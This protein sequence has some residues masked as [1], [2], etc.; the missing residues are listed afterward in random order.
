MLVRLPASLAWVAHAAQLKASPSLA[1]ALELLKLRAL[2][3]IF[4]IMIKMTLS[5]LLHCLLPIGWEVFLPTR[6]LPL[7]ELCVI[8]CVQPG[9]CLL[10]C[11]YFRSLF[12][13]TFLL[14]PFLWRSGGQKQNLVSSVESLINLS[15]NTFHCLLGTLGFLNADLWMDPVHGNFEARS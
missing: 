6:S 12:S 13:F 2:C 7:L 3:N 9:F 11:V 5:V 1:V 14:L 8:V 15:Q 4:K 10:I